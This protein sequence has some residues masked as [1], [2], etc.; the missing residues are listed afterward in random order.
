MM[1][2]LFQPAIGVRCVPPGSINVQFGAAVEGPGGRWV[3]CASTNEDGC[4]LPSIFEIGPGRHQIC[5]GLAPVS[6]P[7]EAL[8]VAWELASIAAA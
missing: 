7:K 4:F 2:P 5:T 1:Y 8:Q 6:C 3:P